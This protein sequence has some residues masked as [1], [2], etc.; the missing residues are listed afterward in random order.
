MNAASTN[1]KTGA[2]KGKKGKKKKGS[3]M[4]R[5]IDIDHVLELSLQ[6]WL[7]TMEAGEALLRKT[8]AKFDKNEDGRLSFQEFEGIVR[9]VEGERRV[10]KTGRPKDEV[11]SMY[12]QALLVS[13][14]GGHSSGRVDEEVRVIT[15]K[16][17]LTVASYYNLGV[18]DVDPESRQAAQLDAAVG[19]ADDLGLDARL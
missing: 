8:F 7:E 10:S 14:G 1:A 15:I 4:V 17:F 5:Q 12:Q 2:K 16:G 18:P 9:A 11:R 19:G 6:L 3:D 13:L